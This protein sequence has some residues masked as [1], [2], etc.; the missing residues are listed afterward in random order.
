M[1]RTSLAAVTACRFAAS[2]AAQSTW[3]VDAL[4]LC[5]AGCRFE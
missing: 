5:Q 4:P 2:A 1:P 3:G